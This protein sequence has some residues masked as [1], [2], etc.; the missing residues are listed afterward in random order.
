MTGYGEKF[1]KNFKTVGK[2]KTQ[3]IVLASVQHYSEMIVDVFNNIPPMDKIF[4]LAALK[5][6]NQSLSKSFSTDSSL[7]E[8]L[9]RIISTE[10]IAL[11][12]NPDGSNRQVIRIID[13][14]KE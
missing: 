9:I 4:F 7:A 1:I 8:S 2:E 3:E 10:T 13:E 14:H 5:I 6:V 11:S 12:T